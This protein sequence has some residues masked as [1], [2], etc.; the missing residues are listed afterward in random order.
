MVGF[1]LW[2]MS[3]DWSQASLWLALRFQVQH[4]YSL[5]ELQW[6]VAPWRRWSVG[7]WWS[8]HL[9][10]VLTFKLWGFCVDVIGLIYWYNRER[11]FD[12]CLVCGI[13]LSLLYTLVYVGDVIYEL[14]IPFLT[15]QY[16]EMTGFWTLLLRQNHMGTPWKWIMFHNPW[17][18]QIR[19]GSFP[20]LDITAG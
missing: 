4:S 6:V 12:Y 2:R 3:N 10:G 5:V 20:R 11:M 7:W 9:N 18:F 13:I 14:G 16:H 19:V 15:S 1:L 17:A 8:Y